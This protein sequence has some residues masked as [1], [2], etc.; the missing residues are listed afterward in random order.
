MFSNNCYN[1][2][3]AILDYLCKEMLRIISDISLTLV[4]SASVARTL[5]VRCNFV[6]D[7]E[8]IWQK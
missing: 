7:R 1:H 6:L 3:T 5:F 4:K 2:V 8:L